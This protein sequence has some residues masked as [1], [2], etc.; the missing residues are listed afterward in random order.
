MKNK[1]HFLAWLKAAGLRALRTFAQAFI[2]SVGAATLLDQVRW[3]EALSASALAALLSILMSII[4]G[5]PE[6]PEEGDLDA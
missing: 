5:L 1:E 6:V 3:L 2:A 4:T